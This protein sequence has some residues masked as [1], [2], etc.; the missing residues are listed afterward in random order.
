L[1]RGIEY[2]EA[3]KAI[4]D[5]AAANDYSGF[6]PHAQYNSAIDGGFDLFG[7]K[8]VLFWFFLIL[9]IQFRHI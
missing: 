5:W 2:K 7:G 4:S 6:S 3:Y 1:T 8:F 9:S